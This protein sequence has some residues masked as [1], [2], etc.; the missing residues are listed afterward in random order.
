MCSVCYRCRPWMYLWFVEMLT[1]DILSW[2]PGCAPS[3]SKWRVTMCSYW[4]ER[5]TLL[6]V[7]VMVRLSCNYV[8]WEAHTGVCVCLCVCV[9][10]C[11]CVDQQCGERPSLLKM[12][13]SSTVWRLVVSLCPY[14]FVHVVYKCSLGK[15]VLNLCRHTVHL[16]TVGNPKLFPIQ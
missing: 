4:R 9:C 16:A 14:T 6:P 3:W 1:A 13:K 5:D 2:R 11:V 12:H 8:H 7:T 15:N 10:V